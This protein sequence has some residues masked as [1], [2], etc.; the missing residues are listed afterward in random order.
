M[1][2]SSSTPPLLIAPSPHLGRLPP[3]PWK[4]L[5]TGATG[6]IGSNLVR[7]LQAAGHHVR[8][9][10][11]ERPL[12]CAPA[13]AAGGGAA[14][15]AIELVPLDVCDA[16]SLEPAVQGV[17]LVYHLAARISIVGPEGGLVE[18]TNVAGSRHV[19]RACLR[20]GVRRLVHFSSV[21]AFRH[22][23]DGVPL[24]VDSPRANHPSD[25][26]YDFSKFRGEEEVR[27]AI[28][29]GLDA[30][31]LNPAG[32]LGPRDEQPSRMGQVFLDLQRRRMPAMVAGGFCWVDVR[33]VVAAALAAAQGGRRARSYLLAG[34]WASTAELAALWSQVSGVAAPRFTCPMWLAR[35][36]APGALRWSR[37]MRS[38][39]KLTPEGLRALR[40]GCRRVDCRDA[41][42]DLGFRARPLEETIADTYAWLRDERLL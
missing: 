8:A 23:P 33:D 35:A 38:S 24:T 16:A 18:R 5:V 31:I 40:L 13:W 20:A 4:V 15:A 32:V 2:S 34:R 26:A 22:R 6:H 3:P 27:A 11:H 28:A 30:V 21:H 12:T 25:G 10:I 14:G 9:G 36:V 42:R 39:A 37:L 41:E 17:D 1:P 7:A 19:A 29:D